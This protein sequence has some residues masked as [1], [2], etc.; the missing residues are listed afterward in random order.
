MPGRIR[1]APVPLSACWASVALPIPLAS[2]DVI[3]NG[4]IAVMLWTWPDLSKG[5]VEVSSIATQV[6]MMVG[7]LTEALMAGPRSRVAG[8]LVRE[9]GC[10]CQ[11]LNTYLVCSAIQAPAETAPSTLYAASGR[12]PIAPIERH[13]PLKPT[14]T[15]QAAAAIFLP[16]M[17]LVARVQRR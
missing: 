17:Y 15:L 10:A 14:V 6:K 9:T 7:A 12:H 11:G 2:L 5:V 8:A 13:R 4:S 16:L 1:K 3:E